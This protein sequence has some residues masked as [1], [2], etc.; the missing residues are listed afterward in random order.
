MNE[1]YGRDY[2]DD[3]GNGTREDWEDRAERGSRT[4]RDDSRG[5]RPRG[6]WGSGRSSDQGSG[7][8]SWSNPGQDRSQFGSQGGRYGHPEYERSEQG[9]EYGSRSYG[10]GGGYTGGGNLGRS[11][12]SGSAGGN[13]GGQYGQYG[14]GGQYGQSGGLYGQRNQSSYGQGGQYGGYSEGMGQEGG[15]N[16]WPSSTGSGSAGSRREGGFFGKGPKGYTRS[17]ERIREDVC[18]R[19]SD[20]DEVDASDI[21]VTVKE[22]EVTLEG[23]VPDRRSKHRA[24][25]ITEAVGGVREVHNSLRPQKGLLQEVGDRVTGRAESEQHGHTGSGTRNSGSSTSGATQG[26]FAR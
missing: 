2:E 13:R 9:S 4:Q 7:G 3:E 12:S 14:Q 25:D 21:T 16:R 18:D 24:E 5:E 23:T 15:S 26:S 6:N 8:R 17:D 20:D 19:L 10:A 1:R 11:Y 22:G